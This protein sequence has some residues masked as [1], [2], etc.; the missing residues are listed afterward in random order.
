MAKSFFRRLFGLD[1]ES[2]ETEDVLNVS[3][4]EPTIKIYQRLPLTELQLA[5]YGTE[6]ATVEL[7]DYQA[8]D[9]VA[10]QQR[11][12][13]DYYAEALYR[14]G[15]NEAATQLF[16]YIA[17][18][19]S[20]LVE[21]GEL[22]RINILGN[23]MEFLLEAPGDAQP[24]H[25]QKAILYRN[26]DSSLETEFSEPFLP[27]NYFLPTSMLLLLQHMLYSL[28]DE[29]MAQLLMLLSAM[30]T[31]YVTRYSYTEQEG[32]RLAVRHALSQVEHYE[33][34]VAATQ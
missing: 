20:H 23:L 14:L 13:L 30:H 8:A 11:L 9:A 24:L 16:Q 34:D 4:P 7:L 26:E 19:C 2:T 25:F 18:L 21:K 5:F 28:N 17:A 31:F 22:K 6:K 3:E 15:G 27:L 29:D 12:V 33:A 32:R 10:H 1:E